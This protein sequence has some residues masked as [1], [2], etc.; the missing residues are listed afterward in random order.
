M[1]D[2]NKQKD[3]DNQKEITDLKMTYAI[4][5]AI[6]D[7][8]Q[9]SDLVAGLVDRKKLIL[10]DDGKVTGLDEQIKGLKE[11]KPFLFKQEES[12]QKKGFFRLG[13][14]ESGNSGGDAKPTMKEAIAAKLNM[15]N[16]KE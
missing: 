7:T 16:G 2:Q 14:K 9:D 12:G 1:Q 15:A 4:R 6:S 8:A 10:G 3:L 5:V 13:A 11:S